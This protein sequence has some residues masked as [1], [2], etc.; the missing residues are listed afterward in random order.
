MSGLYASIT[1]LAGNGGYKSC[2]NQISST[3][4][5]LLGTH[6]S[7]LAAGR[8]RNEGFKQQTAVESCQTVV[9]FAWQGLCS[10]CGW[11]K[12]P[13]WVATVVESMVGHRCCHWSLLVAD[14]A[15]DVQCLTMELRIPMDSWYLIIADC[16]P[17]QSPSVVEQLIKCLGERSPKLQTKHGRSN[18][19]FVAAAYCLDQI[20]NHHEPIS[21]TINHHQRSSSF[22]IYRHYELYA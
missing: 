12:L 3:S 14:V 4:C 1:F 22:I 8:W 9:E 20:M 16:I 2:S 10:N 15:C 17:I 7:V 21:T 13:P 5:N 18:P 6:P 11:L 19:H